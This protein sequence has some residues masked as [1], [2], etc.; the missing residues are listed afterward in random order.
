MIQINE[1]YRIK[2]E[3]NYYALQEMRIR[4]NEDGTDEEIW[5]S[6]TFHMTLE[7]ALMGCR[8]NAVKKLVSRAETV[9]LD[10]VI[11]ELGEIEKS[12]KMAIRESL[13]M[14]NK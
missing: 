11:T 10:E 13:G 7:N 9:K 14:V 6:I 8:R 1:Y 2:A 3:S 4:K 12:F 5:E